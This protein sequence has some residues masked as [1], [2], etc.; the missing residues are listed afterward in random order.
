[1]AEMSDE[2][3]QELFESW[4]KGLLE[5]ID[6][7]HLMSLESTTTL[8]LENNNFHESTLEITLFEEEENKVY[9][10][11]YQLEQKLVTLISISFKLISCSL[12]KFEMRTNQRINKLEKAQER[13]KCYSRM[14]E[15]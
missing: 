14:L 11:L 3:F 2:V 10:R 12:C 13:Q 4:S 9:L 6:Y 1:M 5:V 15:K 8:I 7:Q